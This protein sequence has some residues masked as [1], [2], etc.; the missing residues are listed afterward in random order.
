MLEKK[1]V[2]L[3]DMC[4]ESRRY[5][6]RGG[7]SL[8]YSYRLSFSYRPSAVVEYSPARGPVVPEP[9]ALKVVPADEPAHVERRVHGDE[10][11]VLPLDAKHVRLPVNYNEKFH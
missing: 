9:C 2:I 4:L 7:R 10:E 11:G 1:N 3:L 8:F 6:G 5:N